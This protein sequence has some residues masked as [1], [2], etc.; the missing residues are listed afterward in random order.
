MQIS[1][2]VTRT[3]LE[4]QKLCL[5][6]IYPLSIGSL[7]VCGQMGE[8]LKLLGAMRWF[9]I[10][11]NQLAPPSAIKNKLKQASHQNFRLLQNFQWR[12][13]RGGRGRSWKMNEVER[14]S[15]TLAF[16]PGICRDHAAPQD[17]PNFCRHAGVQIL[18]EPRPHEFRLSLSTAAAAAKHSNDD[19]LVPSFALMNLAAWPRLK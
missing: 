18:S 7:R 3:A 2:A 11:G 14:V 19:A 4:T 6:S 9:I 16:A 8:D 12:Y 10:D 13:E 1:P 17:A 15:L 5:R